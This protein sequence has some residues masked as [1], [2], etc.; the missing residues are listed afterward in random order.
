MG[1]MTG[2]PKIRAMEIIE[3]YEQSKRGVYS[4]AAGYFT[5]NG[6]F[7]FNVIIRSLLY[8]ESKKYLSFQVGSAITFASDAEMEYQECMLKAKAMFKVL[9]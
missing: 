1:S 9:S 4:G 7:D 2:A 3:Q 8:N 5:G 6:D